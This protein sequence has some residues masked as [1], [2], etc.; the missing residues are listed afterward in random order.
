MKKIFKYSFLLAMLV[1]AVAGCKK[2]DPENSKFSPPVWIHGEWEWAYSDDI[3]SLIT[4][5]KF[6]S[7][8]VIA[9]Y[10]VSDMPYSPAILTFSEIGKSS[11]ATAME[12]VK[13]DEIYEITVI[14]LT[15]ELEYKT[16][17]RFKKGDGTYIDYTNDSP[18]ATKLTKK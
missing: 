13:A 4:N 7:N 1:I 14:L 12:T 17:S 3:K 5:Y 8:D 11:H 18:V 16:V 6:T 2:D 10:I 9:T 15:S